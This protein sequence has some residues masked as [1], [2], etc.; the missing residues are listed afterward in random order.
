MK[1]TFG[2]LSKDKYST[3]HLLLHL[4]LN[5]F[6]HPVFSILTRS[7]AVSS[8]VVFISY[9]AIHQRNKGAVQKL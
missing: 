1:N 2:G 7:G 6:P 4:S 9:E 5:M 8:I 3:W